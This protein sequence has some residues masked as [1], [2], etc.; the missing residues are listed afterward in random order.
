[1]QFLEPWMGKKFKTISVLEIFKYI[2]YEV[3]LK[4]TIDN[5]RQNDSLQKDLMTQVPIPTK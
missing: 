2:H 4:N 1:M 3:L 5:Q